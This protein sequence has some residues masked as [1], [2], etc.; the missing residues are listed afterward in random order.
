MLYLL[1]K[2]T[3]NKYLSYYYD[4]NWYY[5]C[6]YQ[7]KCLQDEHIENTNIIW[8][9]TM[10]HTND[11]TNKMF[12]SVFYKG[13]GNC[14]LSPYHMFNVANVY[15]DEMFISVYYKGNGNYSLSS[16]HCLVWHCK[17]VYRC[18]IFIDIL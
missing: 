15:A 16:C 18:D 3:A 1:L 6:S 17:K 7:S 12:L 9:T 2:F 8:C 5:F 11:N 10:F 4:M 13:D 14:S